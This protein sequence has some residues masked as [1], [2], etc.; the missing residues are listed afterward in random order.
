MARRV[1]S[2][3]P[4]AREGAGL[5]Q[6]A[7][8]LDRGQRHV[9]PLAD[10][11]DLPQMG[12]RGAGRLRVLAQGPALRH[13]PPRAQ[14]GRQ[15]DQAVSRFRR[16]RARPQARSPALAVRA[17]Q[18]IRRGRFRRL[19]RTAAGHV[20]RPSPASRRRG[21]PRQLQDAG[22]HR[23]AAQVQRCRSVFTDHATYPNI[24]DITG[25]F[26]YARL[27]QGKDTVAD[28]L[29]AEGARRMGRSGCSTWARGQRAGRPAAR[30]RRRP[31]RRPRRATCLPTSST[32]ARCARRPRRWR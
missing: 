30:R 24:A 11:G 3:G 29:S 31:S 5:R 32:R 4:A 22:V 16:D 19:S 2:E 8:D 7:A 14:G 13:Q 26:V 28:R 17:V 20:Q 18:E 15:L 10:A 1:L 27:Q 25:D 12:E 9:L 21:P 23:A 6:R